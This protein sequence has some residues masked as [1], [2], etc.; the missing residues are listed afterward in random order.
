MLKCFWHDQEHADGRHL[1]INVSKQPFRLLIERH[2]HGVKPC[3]L[4]GYFC[5]NIRVPKLLRTQAIALWNRGR[6]DSYLACV[7]TVKCFVYI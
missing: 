4:T 1:P 6:S 3:H 7:D 5:R 2:L